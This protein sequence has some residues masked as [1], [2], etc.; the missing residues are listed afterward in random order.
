VEILPC[1]GSA[2]EIVTESGTKLPEKA[3]CYAPEKQQ[4]LSRGKKVEFK[5][6]SVH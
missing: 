6:K 1:R 3:K 5:G 2:K 4:N